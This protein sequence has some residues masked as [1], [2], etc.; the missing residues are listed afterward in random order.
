MKSVKEFGGEAAYENLQKM[1]GLSTYPNMFDKHPPFQIDGNF[2]ACAAISGMLAQSNENR[3]VLLP[4]LPKAWSTGSVK[5]LCLVGN[6]ELEMH[7]ENGTL[8]KA[9]IT[10]H[11]NYD[12]NVIYANKSVKLQMQAGEI[13]ELTF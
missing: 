7:W 4:A 6:A 8:K 3:I 5:G 12:K 11:N 1:L 9:I 2:G 10:A 13:K